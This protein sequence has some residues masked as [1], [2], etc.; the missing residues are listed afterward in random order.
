MANEKDFA[1]TADANKKR[2]G[3]EDKGRGNGSPNKKPRYESSG[4][5]K[6]E[7]ELY[8]IFRGVPDSAQCP[9]HTKGNHNS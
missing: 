4:G 8:N 1:D 5:T 7:S 2:K 9:L 3:N 6:T